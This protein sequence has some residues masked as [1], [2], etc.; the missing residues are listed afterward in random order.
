MYHK[1]RMDKD[2]F[3]FVERCI[4]NYHLNLADLNNRREY[5][6]GL[7]TKSPS[8]FSDTFKIEGGEDVPILQRWVEALD[9]D[10][11]IKRLECLTNPITDFLSM[12]A[13]DDRKL[14]EMRY[15]QDC[16]WSRIAE[17]L[18]VSVDTARRGWRG[19]LIFKAAQMIFGRLV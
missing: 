4:R 18:H 8:D 17:T 2:L 12:L 3:R 13:D 7:A 19:R 5:M 16:S 9:R 11:E 10:D 14:I 1:H 6:R 15:F